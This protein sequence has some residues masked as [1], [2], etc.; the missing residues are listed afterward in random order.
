MSLKHT[1]IKVRKG[2]T[3]V[4]IAGTDKGKRGKVLRV[5]P[6]KSAVLVEKV[7]LVK[8]HT[9]PN[10]ANPQGG[11]VEKEAPVHVSNV[12]VVDPEKDVPTR[13]GVRVQQDGTRQRYAKKSGAVL[14]G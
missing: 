1:R 7:R 8:R 3:V 14:E 6:K 9:R 5:L 10:Q 4:V 2:D 11:I 12:M 13:I